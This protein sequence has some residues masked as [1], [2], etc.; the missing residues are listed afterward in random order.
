M[1]VN[2]LGAFHCCQVAVPHMLV[3]GEGAIV[4]IASLCGLGA[5]PEIPIAYTSSKFAVVGFTKAVALEF[6]DRNIRCNAVCP[7]A[8]N[9]AMRDTL[10]QRMAE[11][12]GISV[13]EARQMEDETIGMARGGEP[14]EIADCV[15]YLAGPSASYVTGTAIPV[16]GGMV[17]GL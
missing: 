16:A 3:A 10:F 9:T 5:I 11:E 1:N 17:P 7:G 14:E 15:A 8:I 2:L 4:N 13:D 6:A 12:H